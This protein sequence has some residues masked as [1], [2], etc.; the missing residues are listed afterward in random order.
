MIGEE[1][2]C[3][4]ADDENG[5][6]HL[7]QAEQL[8][9]IIDTSYKDYHVKKVYFDAYKQEQVSGGDRYPE[10]NLEIMD[11]IVNGSLIVNYTGHGGELGWSDEKV[12]D[13]PMIN[14]LENINNLPLFITAT[15]EFSRFDN[16]ELVSAG[17][18]VLLNPNGGGI[19]LLT[20]T[21]L[22]FSTANFS[23]NKN[24]YLEAFKNENGH[25]PR[26]GDI[27]K[28]TKAK[29]NGILQKNFAL[30]GDPALKLS[31]PENKIITTEV[32]LQG[33]PPNTRHFVFFV[34]SYC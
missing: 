5:N 26:L 15:C 2:I 8:V 30:L 31:Y 13:I 19:G 24:F 21:R 20:T 1:K 14:S 34:K 6:I 27:I 32:N 3:F 17:E 28:K 16:P 9:E 29:S 7:S 23:L 10:V 4:I 18:L 11:A 25:L 22:A 12:F 33:H